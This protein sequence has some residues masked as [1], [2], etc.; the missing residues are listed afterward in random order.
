MQNTI[1]NTLDY[2]LLLFNNRFQKSGGHYWPPTL[3]NAQY[4]FI[5]LQKIKKFE[6]IIFDKDSKL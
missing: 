2:H 1:A 6:N 3:K 5:Y 4:I